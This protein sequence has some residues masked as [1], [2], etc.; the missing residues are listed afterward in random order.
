MVDVC[1]AASDVVSVTGVVGIRLSLMSC[2][3]VQN[4]DPAGLRYNSVTA[5]SKSTV[6]DQIRLEV[7]GAGLRD[8]SS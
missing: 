6:L 7:R 5:K 3:A 4:A 2:S 1:P 8:T